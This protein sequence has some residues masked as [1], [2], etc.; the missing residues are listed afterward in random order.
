M[1]HPYGFR[2]TWKKWHPVLSCSPM[3]YITLLQPQRD[4][5]LSKSAL[6]YKTKTLTQRYHSHK[7][8]LEQAAAHLSLWLGSERPYSFPASSLFFL[9]RSHLKEARCLTKYSLWIRDT[10]LTVFGLVYASWLGILVHSITMTGF[11]L[12]KKNWRQLT[13]WGGEIYCTEK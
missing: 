12:N 5:V 7:K 13:A 1:T 3:W 4:T 2:W 8:I 10:L 9:Y 6:P 11:F